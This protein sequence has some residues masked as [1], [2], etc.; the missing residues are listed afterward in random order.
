MSLLE[1]ATD[2]IKDKLTQ[3]CEHGQIE[4]SERVLSVIAGG[5]IV[6][7]S[8]R[9]MIKHPL[10]SFIGITLGGVLVARGVTGKCPFKGALAETEIDR[11]E[12]IAVIEHRYRIK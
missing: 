11:D 6:G 12:E 4:G 1:S 3:A 8:L 9:R 5:L 2:I 10:S 7:R